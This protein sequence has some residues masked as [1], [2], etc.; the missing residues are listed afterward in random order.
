MWMKPKDFLRYGQTEATGCVPSVFG[1]FQ[2]TPQTTTASMML[3][4]FWKRVRFARLLS[5]RRMH[6][7]GSHVGWGFLKAKQRMF[8]EVNH[9]AAI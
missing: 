7:S 1:L 8:R 9:E 3:T 6:V 5:P 2:P 4:G